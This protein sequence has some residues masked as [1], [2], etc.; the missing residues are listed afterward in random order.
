M[1]HTVNMKVGHERNP[2]NRKGQRNGGAAWVWRSREM[3]ARALVPF[4][5]VNQLPST[6]LALLRELPER[7]EA[8]T[9]HNHVHGTL[10]QVNG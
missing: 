3:A 9:R 4:I 6:A 10:L 2:G 1:L 8:T 7:A 5:M